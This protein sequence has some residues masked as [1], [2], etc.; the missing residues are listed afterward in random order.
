M[1]HGMRDMFI[2]ISTLGSIHVHLD[3]LQSMELC[4]VVG[5]IASGTLTSI[6]SIWVIDSNFLHCT[7]EAPFSRASMA[8]HESPRPQL[9]TGNTLAQINPIGLHSASISTSSSMKSIYS[10][11]ASKVKQNS[12]AKASIASNKVFIHSGPRGHIHRCTK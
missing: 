5:M 6:V 8:N 9:S 3:T 11:W 10:N 4:M 12:F 7:I 1:A 2:K